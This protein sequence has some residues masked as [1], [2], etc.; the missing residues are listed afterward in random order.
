MNS[1]ADLR[2]WAESAPAGTTIPARA[3]VEILADLEA[4][5][6]AP[7]EGEPRAA[8][9]SW[10]ERVWQVPDGTILSVPEVAEAAGRSEHWVYR[11]ANKDRRPIPHQKRAGRLVFQAGAVRRWLQDRG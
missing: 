4:A 5:G 9:S 7:L 10:R 3:L 2:R 8:S 1:L 6:P 11:Q